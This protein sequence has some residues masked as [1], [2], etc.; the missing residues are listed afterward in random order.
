MVAVQHCTHFAP[1]NNKTGYECGE[2][3]STIHANC[4]QHYKASCR[5]AAEAHC[6]RVIDFRAPTLCSQCRSL[7]VG[8]TKQGMHCSTCRVCIF[9]FIY[10]FIYH[11]FTSFK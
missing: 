5:S 7:L 4:R 9:L 8:L 6:F 11:Y 3:K 2:C 1:A 10:L